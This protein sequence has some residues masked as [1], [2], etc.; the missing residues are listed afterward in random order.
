MKPEIRKWA[1]KGPIEDQQGDLRKNQQLWKK[2]E[3]PPVHV[4]ISRWRL[5]PL[6]PREAGEN[7]KAIKKWHKRAEMAEK[8]KQ[9]Y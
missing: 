1:Q 9:K 8:E 5:G 3:L 7:R 2:A 6:G 4:N